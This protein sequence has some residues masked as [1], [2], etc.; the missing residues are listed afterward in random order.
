M[1]NQSFSADD[2][3]IKPS[4]P[5]YSADDLGIKPGTS[6]SADDLGLPPTAPS[7]GANK[8]SLPMMAS[9]NQPAGQ[10]MGMGEA[11]NQVLGQ[12]IGRDTHGLA[13]DLKN[14]NIY[15]NTGEG[16]YNMLAAPLSWVDRARRAAQAVGNEIARPIV[17]GDYPLGNPEDTSITTPLATAG[18]KLQ[19]IA[20]QYKGMATPGYQKGTVGQVETMAPSLMAAKAG[21]IRTGGAVFGSQGGSQMAQ[22]AEQSGATPT[23]QAAMLFAGTLAG[24]G[25]GTLRPGASAPLVGGETASLADRAVS[26]GKSGA[27]LGGLTAA[28]NAMEKLIYNKD[29]SL[30]DGVPES[31]VLGTLIGAMEAHGTPVTNEEASA[32]ASRAKAD[33]TWFAKRYG[34]IVGPQVKAF[35]EAVAEPRTHE[36]AMADA[37]AAMERGDIKAAKGFKSEAEALKPVAATEQPVATEPPSEPLPATVIPKETDT[38]AKVAEPETA[39]PVE[40][41]GEPGPALE[42]PTT[43]STGA[44]I[45][46]TPEGINNFWDTFKDSK[47]VNE[48]GEPIV[49][50][51]GGKGDFEAFDPEKF[52]GE[53]DSG[54]HGKGIYATEFPEYASGYAEKGSEPG[55]VKPVYYDLKNPF[56]IPAREGKTRD[57]WQAEYDAKLKEAGVTDRANPEQMTDELKQA[58]YDGLVM[59]KTDP[60]SGENK[61]FEAVAFDPKQVKSAIGNTGEFSP[62]N[63]SMLHAGLNPF[64]A[65]RDAAEAAKKELG[66]PEGATDMDLAREVLGR[67]G[68]LGGS[69]KETV[70]RIMSKVKGIG[71][72]MAQALAEHLH[73]AVSGTK[74]GQLGAV[75]KDVKAYTPEEEAHYSQESEAYR[76]MIS[77]RYPGEE[78]ATKRN[79]LYKKIPSKA[80]I[81]SDFR[82]EPSE[83]QM[84]PPSKPSEATAY[85]RAA[86]FAKGITQPIRDLGSVAKAL[87]SNDNI[88]TNRI[89][90]ELD[91]RG[92]IPTP[93]EKGTL[94]PPKLVRPMIF[95]EDKPTIKRDFKR[96]ILGRGVVATFNKYMRSPHNLEEPVFGKYNSPTQDL[97][98]AVIATINNANNMG[99]FFKDLFRTTGVKDNSP[100]MQEVAKPLFDRFVRSRAVLEPLDAQKEALEKNVKLAQKRGEGV[101]IAEK[102][103]DDWHDQNRDAYSKA[104]AE[105]K[106]VSKA[107]QDMLKD[108][109]SKYGDARVALAAEYPEGKAP[110]WIKLTPQEELAADRFRDMMKASKERLEQLGIPTIEGDYVTHLTKYL[111]EDTGVPDERRVPKE[112]LK[113]GKREEGSS[114]WLPS[115]HAAAADYVPNAS[116]KMATQEFY[117]KWR[118]MIDPKDPNSLSNPAS[119]NYAPNA[120]KYL[121]DMFKTLDTPEAHDFIDTAINAGRNYENAKLLS[122]NIRVGWKHFAGKLPSLLAQNDVWTAPGALGQVKALVGKLSEDSHI[123]KAIDG[124]GIST[125]DWTKKAKLVSYFANTREILGMLRENPFTSGVEEAR[126]YGIGSAKSTRMF[127]QVFGDK[128]PDV[129]ANMRHGMQRVTSNPVAMTEA[130]EN[131]LD[132][133]SSIEKG[134]ARGLSP[135]QNIKAFMGNILDFNFRGGADSPRLVKNQKTRYFIQFAQTPMKL[136]ELK[137]KLL[138]N[139]WKGGEDIYG[140]DHTANMV[141]HVVMTGLAL[142]A[143]KSAGLNAKDSTLHLPFFNS[144]QWSRLAKMAYFG[145]KMNILDDPEAEEKFNRAKMAFIGS[146]QSTVTGSPLFDIGRDVKTAITVGPSGLV[147]QM[148][149]YNQ[150]KAVSTGEV[151]DGYKDMGAFLTN[152]RTDESKEG[153]EARAARRGV[154]EQR[155]QQ[156][157][158][159]SH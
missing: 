21:G 48:K 136:A 140:T 135:E 118:S 93:Y 67:I 86:G 65:I 73:Q 156:K 43:N 106:S 27:L 131:G 72:D 110:D 18:Q 130:W 71:R 76:D 96:D 129:I 149:I 66:L 24:G 81:I 84:P 23:Q 9:H 7:S 29:K 119:P 37:D 45:H 64:E 116:R 94:E 159:A 52:G 70:V 155:Y 16:F 47:I 32:I 58:G 144:D 105:M 89:F 137:A 61:I 115:A 63:P 11:T 57:Q 78:N 40:P 53:T 141:K 151:P 143:A 113:F 148:P 74:E 6:F 122:A 87:T 121:T 85:D 69:V 13:A 51:H 111:A 30:M 103:L 138:M 139:A 150:L 142:Q 1:P 95:G 19:G 50:Y 108:F 133:L 55:N 17:G 79:E 83:P 124:L 112:I 49:L 97:Q 102:A 145:T 33:P 123:R 3:G 14:K 2:L 39:S 75:G 36:Q 5:V 132:L 146:P 25:Y 158:E 10:P 90:D 35:N 42:R 153:A 92:V 8:V 41:A 56:E 4:E 68:K 157:M 101:D 44:P 107:H 128:A 125:S 54:A 147:K 46:A 59:R 152:E 22:Q 38:N 100:E 117:N 126:R 34:D 80:S 12:Y 20:E 82:G 109:A 154:R 104:I 120:S 98:S 114:Q 99:N 134:Q 28:S 26:G 15:S 127:T 77:R 91:K 60:A 88:A 31:A 62:E